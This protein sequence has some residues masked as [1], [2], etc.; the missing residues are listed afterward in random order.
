MVYL[1]IEKRR[2]FCKSCKKPFIE[3]V[4]GIVK[5]RKSK[6]RFRKHIDWCATNFSDLKRVVTNGKTE[7][8]NRKVKLTQRSAYGFKKFD[9]NRLKLI[10]L[11]K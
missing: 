6:T 9:N 7:G 3:P 1:K 4:Q 10:Y 11:R 5:G 8:F 2:F